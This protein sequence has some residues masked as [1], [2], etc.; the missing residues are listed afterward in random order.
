MI[1]NFSWYLRVR[2]QPSDMVPANNI[3]AVGTVPAN[4]AILNIMMGA[5]YS[6]QQIWIFKSFFPSPENLAILD[7]RGF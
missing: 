5:A 2:F 4:N 6:I 7:L 1:K 3:L